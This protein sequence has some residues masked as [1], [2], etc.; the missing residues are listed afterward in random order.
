MQA[1]VDRGRAEA[2]NLR[3]Q[4][5]DLRAEH[6]AALKTSDEREST[7]TLL[8]ENLSSLKSQMEIEMSKLDGK[9]Q[10]IAEHTIRCDELVVRQQHL[11][12]ELE[13]QRA[14]T[15]VMYDENKALQDQ[16][17]QL[18]SEIDQLNDKIDSANQREEELKSHLEETKQLNTSQEQ[19]IHK[20]KAS[21]RAMQEKL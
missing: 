8:E 18:R 13:E 20:L 6:S 12:R 5:R 3:Q 14:S 15:A 9:D 7:I 21:V 2:E 19:N 10:E 17:M 4:L 16:I 11:E 1:E